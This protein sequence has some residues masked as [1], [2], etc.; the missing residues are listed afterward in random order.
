MSEWQVNDLTH[1]PAVVDAVL[2]GLN[3]IKTDGA[4]VL[5]L[6]GDLGAGKTTFVQLLARQL[7]VEETVT[8][9][10]F[11]VMK[12]YETT[13][14]FSNLIHIDAY[15]IETEE[16][17]RVLGFEGLLQSPQTLICIEWAE[18]IK[19]LLPTHTHH[20]TFTPDGETRTVT[21]RHG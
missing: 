1:M 10:T 2:T 5:A 3:E 13:H 18:R 17:M 16:E 14:D 15:R 9:P 19:N 11:V 7:G 6:H 12:Q 20:L 8:S 21:L 4:T